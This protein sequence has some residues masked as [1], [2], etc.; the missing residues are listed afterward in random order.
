MPFAPEWLYACS[1]RHFSFALESPTC[2]FRSGPTGDF[3]ID[4]RLL[5][6]VFVR[7]SSRTRIECFP[8]RL[9][10]SSMHK[11]GIISSVNPDF[12]AN[13]KLRLKAIVD[14]AVRFWTE[15]HGLQ[16][17]LRGNLSWHGPRSVLHNIL[18]EL[19]VGVRLMLYSFHSTIYLINILV[20]VHLLCLRLLLIKS[21]S[22]IPLF[23]H[24][25][26]QDSDTATF[27][28]K[29]TSRIVKGLIPSSVMFLV[30]SIPHHAQ[31]LP[32]RSCRL[33]D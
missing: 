32:C 9:T 12:A 31:G 23:P 10:E 18:V 25:L 5:E 28:E 14:Y 27:M 3:V 21:H 30:L 33:K 6:V 4:K 20:P 2:C 8:S 1:S 26:M 19:N 13:P 29:N 11:L 16:C 7:A 24:A 15:K 17:S 22:L